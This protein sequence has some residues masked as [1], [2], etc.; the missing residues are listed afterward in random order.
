MRKAD[1]QSE[2]K[3]KPR[4][5]R[6]F[7]V[8]KMIGPLPRSESRY[9]TGKTNALAAGSWPFRNLRALRPHSCAHEPAYGL[10]RD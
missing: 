5:F 2:G 7:I 6:Q 4:L 10:C 3:M 8:Q 1:E 9:L